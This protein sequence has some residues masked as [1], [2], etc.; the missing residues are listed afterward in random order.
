MKRTMDCQDLNEQKMLERHRK[1]VRVNKR[2]H[3]ER[4]EG[5]KQNKEAKRQEKQ[6]AGLTEVYAK[7]NSENPP[8]RSARRPKRKMFGSPQRGTACASSASSLWFT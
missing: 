1:T 6:K 4:V 5:I 8:T 7:W 2:K 3:E